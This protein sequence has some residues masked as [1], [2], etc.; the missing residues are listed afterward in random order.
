MAYISKKEEG[1]FL[2]LF[3][4]DGYVLDFSDNSFD[5]FTTASIGEALKTKYGMSK[6]K[7]LVAY[8]YS[9]SDVDRTKLIVD[10]FHH[11]EEKME[12][13]YNPDYVDPTWWSESNTSYKENY[14]KLYQ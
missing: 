4:R 10:L 2:L 13:E 3:N 8:L 14:A 6:G 7:S 9:A 5:V 11:Y 12:Y 1:T